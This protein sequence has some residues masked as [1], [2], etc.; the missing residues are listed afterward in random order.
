VDAY[1]LFKPARRRLKR[2]QILGSFINQLHVADLAEVGQPPFYPKRNKGVRYLLVIV[3]SLS[4]VCFIRPMKD[5]KATSVRDALENIYQFPKNRCDMLLTDEGKEFLGVCNALYAKYG[6]NRYNTQSTE[7]KGSQA[8]RKILDIKRMISR[9][10]VA[11]NTHEYVSVL[12]LIE[13]NLNSRRHRV[14]KM[15]PNA[16]NLD[17][18]SEVFFNSLSTSKT[19]I[20][21]SVGDYVRVSKVKMFG[22]KA[23]RGAWSRELY[24]IREIDAKQSVV[25]YYLVDL[26]GENITGKF[27]NEELQKVK[28]PE[29][30]EID[31]VLKTKKVGKVKHYL[32]SFKDYLSK[33][34]WIPEGD[35]KRL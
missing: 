30:F 24:K 8:E 22:E 6:I 20:K 9:Y 7:I 25:C 16:V 19:K 29:Y 27:Y 11:K 4:R 5:K 28:K 15:T 17:N 34:T 35:L 23:H 33:P 1:T 26:N 2:R 21:F 13:Q 18:E 10:L 3:D 31:K 14:I 12:P 32:V